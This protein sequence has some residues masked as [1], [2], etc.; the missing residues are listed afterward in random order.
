MNYL[1]YD[2][3]LF[4]QMARITTPQGV[5][6]KSGPFSLKAGTY[7]GADRCIRPLFGEFASFYIDLGVSARRRVIKLSQILPAADAGLLVRTKKGALRYGPLSTKLSTYGSYNLPVVT[8]GWSLEG[9]PDEL[10]QGLYL[11]PPEDT[12]ALSNIFT[13]LHH[14]PED[15]ERKAKILNDFA[16]KKLT[17][18]SVA[19]E[20]LE[21]IND[22]RN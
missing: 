20:I 4:C 10:A 8:A 6:H 15:R 3:I 19:K 21:V 14:H 18:E 9:Y 12:Q 1:I 7:V 16:S 13:Y 5:F 17:W 11:I 2:S 22:N